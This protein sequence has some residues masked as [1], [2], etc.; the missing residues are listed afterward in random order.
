MSNEEIWNKGYEQ[1]RQTMLLDVRKLLINYG[2]LNS[3]IPEIV[4]LLDRELS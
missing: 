4:K 2:P 3:V 1:G